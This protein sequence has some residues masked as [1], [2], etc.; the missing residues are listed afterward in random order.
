MNKILYNKR[1]LRAGWRLLLFFIVALFTGLAFFYPISAPLQ[2]L[3]TQLLSPDPSRAEVLYEGILV[4]ALLA[5]S[6]FMVTVIDRRPWRSLGLPCSRAYVPQIIWGIALG[7]VLVGFGM[8]FSWLVEGGAWQPFPLNGQTLKLLAF[9]L[10]AWSGVALLEELFFRGYLLQTLMEGIGVIP[11][12]LLSSLLFGLAHY[13]NAP[14]HGFYVL[15]AAALGFLMALM[16]LK[17][18]A[19]WLAI[20]FHFAN[21]FF[22][23]LFSWFPQPIPW[24]DFQIDAPGVFIDIAIVLILAVFVVFS[25]QIVPTAEMERAFTSYIYPASWTWLRARLGLAPPP[26]YRHPHRPTGQ[27]CTNCGR[28]ICDECRSTIGQNERS[29][30]PDCA[31]RWTLAHHDLGLHHDDLSPT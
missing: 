1:R 20:G 5:A 25:R 13:E 26:C 27:A 29:F 21:D 7:L 22:I 19:L 3:L 2:W 28:A 15:D 4:P 18:K 10:I 30:C 12:A 11:A 24:K 17:T 16:I 6:W 14:Q 8:L 9:S 23:D 31:E